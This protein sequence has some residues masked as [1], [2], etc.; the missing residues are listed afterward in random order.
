MALFH[1]AASTAEQVIINTA[2]I[3]DDQSQTSEGCQRSGRLVNEMPGTTAD[4]FATPASVRSSGV[5]VW[6]S[7]LSL[8]GVL[9]WMGH[10]LVFAQFQ[11]YDDEG[12]LLITVQQF[13]QGIP[14]YDD[15][16]TQYGPAYYLWQQVLHGM[17]G[18]PV[19]HDATRVV[20]VVVWLG[21][22]ALAAV[23]VWLL[24]RRA[25]LTA[26]GMA[27]AFFHLTQ[28]TFEPGHPQELCLLGVMGAVAVAMWRLVARGRL[29]IPAAMAVGAL[30][31]L[32]ALTK[33]N[34]GAFLMG[35]IALGLVTSLRGSPWRTALVSVVAVSAVAGVAGL[36]HSDLFRSDIA[37][38]V[39]VVWSGLL[40]AFVAGSDDGA[41]DGVV[42]ARELTAYAAG[43]AI[44]S[45][46][47]VVAV[48]AGGTSLRALLE[49]LFVWP[50]R[51][52]AVFWRPLPVPLLA[53]AVAPVWL[54]LAVCRRRNVTVVRRWMPSIALALGLIVFL[55]S[56][57]KAYGLLLA[58]GPP[59][60]W[61][62]LGDASF[63]A[64]ERAARRILAFAAILIALQTYPM[65]DG[66]QIVLG[67]VLFVPVGLVTLADAQRELRTG[68]RQQTAPRSLRRRAT[69]A[70]LAVVVATAIG[71]RMQRLYAD[72]VPLGMRGA[73]AVHVTERDAAT[74]W[75]LTTNLR[76]H[77]DAFLTAPGLNSLHF[78]TGIPPVS[79]LNATL[80][81]ILFDDAQQGRILAAMAPVG[82]LCVAWDQRRMEVLMSAPD[83]ASRPLVASLVRE[84][85]PQAVFGGWEFR[86]RRGNH[87]T[88]LYQGRWL[89]DGGIVVELPPLGYDPVARLA[90]VDL[91]AERTLGDSAGG[92]GVVVIDEEGADAQIHRGIDVSRRRRVVLRGAVASP[93]SD[94]A[95]VVVRLW[96]S[97]GRSLAIV[98]VV[99][100]VPT[101]GAR[102]RPISSLSARPV[103]GF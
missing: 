91:D 43:V 60:A 42:T 32:T 49:G 74:Y 102:E 65:P 18:I 24:T 6:L 11:G 38:W 90:V 64:G 50:L 12:Y 10:R 35:A 7:A 72:G 4:A 16:Y 5:G 66:T 77:C 17:L 39:V 101:D 55:L 62:A 88:L 44:V 1:D 20:T 68:H 57:T 28:L 25:L 100:D 9:A 52:P 98:P 14:L 67:T 73:E 79:T 37:A 78:W 94:H 71:V 47:V 95:S 86:V 87:P 45:T 75:W 70:M 31:A 56:I 63:D 48:I 30:V 46:V 34:V 80:W 2:M 89:D 92:A 93:S 59:L 58:L 27:I 96:A 40:A 8:L 83:T 26:I 97:D 22:S 19:T 103:G 69:L 3:V 61:L 13:L 23:P 54:F 33:V 21:C 36:M 29:G 85:E 15:I 76:E 81:P 51:L 82:R 99:T 53:A 41:G 84:F